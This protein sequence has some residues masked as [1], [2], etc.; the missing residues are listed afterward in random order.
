M[1]RTWWWRGALRGRSDRERG[2]GRVVGG[3]AHSCVRSDRDSARARRRWAWSWRARRASDDP[4]GCRGRRR[5]DRRDFIVVRGPH[6]DRRRGAGTSADARRGRSRRV[7]RSTPKRAELR[8]TLS[9]RGGSVSWCSR[10]SSA[11]CRQTVLVS[12]DAIRD[13]QRQ[14][15]E[16][17][18]IVAEPGGAAALAALISRRYMPEPQ[19]TRRRVDLRRRIRP[20]SISIDWLT[21]CAYDVRGLDVGAREAAPGR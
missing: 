12:D 10:S 4:A 8:P 20:P 9:R 6:Q 13:A 11:T 3:D 19:R 14:V 5:L 17:L 16:T 1:A 21:G 7:G 2:L 18:R 15:V